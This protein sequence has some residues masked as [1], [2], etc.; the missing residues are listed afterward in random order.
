MISP[1]V[2]AAAEAS[3]GCFFFFLNLNLYSA[4]VQLGTEAVTF[5]KTYYAYEVRVGGG[6]Q[7]ELAMGVV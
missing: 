1:N 6:S 3:E 4:R 7:R 2:V 5:V